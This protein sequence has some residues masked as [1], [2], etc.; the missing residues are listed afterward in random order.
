MNAFSSTEPQGSIDLKL[1]VDVVAYEKDGK[2]DLTRFNVDSGEKQYKMRAISASEGER[3]VAVFVSVLLYELT[4]HDSTV[5][6]DR[7]PQ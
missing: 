6:V 7:R 2:K 3:Y 1:V 5:Q 4:G